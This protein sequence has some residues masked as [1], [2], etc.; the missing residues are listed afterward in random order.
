MRYV[1]PFLFLATTFFT[2]RAQTPDTARA[3]VDLTVICLLVDDYDQA[4]TFYTEKL[5]FVVKS[6][7]KYGEGQRWVSL[8]P[9]QGA[10]IELSL[11]LAKTEEDK[12][13]VGRQSGSYPFFV[14]YSEDFNSHYGA[15]KSHG[16]EFT[17]EPARNPWGIGV[18]FKDLYGNTI[19]L[20]GK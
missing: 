14:L 19:Y 16:V 6:D 1:L 9:R 13:M 17:G 11:G 5:G 20:R 4:I 18:T 3:G 8:A 15:Y 10:S 12:A 7:T 2:A